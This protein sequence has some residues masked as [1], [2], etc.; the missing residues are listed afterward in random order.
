LD[1]NPVVTLTIT[2]KSGAN[3]LD[4]SDKIFSTI[5]EQKAEGN[6]PQNIEVTIT[7]DQTHH[8]RNEISN[9]ENSII[10]GMIL[11]IFI[12]FLFLGFRNALFA[13]LAI[14]MS[15]FLSFIILNQS[16]VT[17][18]NMVLYGLIMALGMLVDNAIVVVE[19]VYRL[20]DLGYSA[21]DATKKGISEI[22]MPIISSTLT[23]LAAFIPLLM[24]EGVIGEF[25]SILPKTLI[26]VLSA[27]LFVALILNPAFISTFIK[28]E[29]INTRVNWKKSLIMQQFLLLLPYFFMSPKFIC[30]EIF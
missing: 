5:E 27:S 15:M 24:W 28:I 6:I 19:N 23:T 9:L 11:V 17:L 4:A 22:A 14:P 7:D 26:V 3:I 20:Y 21:L 10:L 16:G 1:N 12:L 2:K 25:M 8:I 18:N 29:D 13:G 30:W